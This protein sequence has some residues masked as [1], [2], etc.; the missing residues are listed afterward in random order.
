MIFLKKIK[1]DSRLLCLVC[2]AVLVCSCVLPAPEADAMLSRLNS[3]NECSIA[4][5]APADMPGLQS[6]EFGV[7]VFRIASVD[8]DVHYTLTDAFSSLTTD[9]NSIK[10][11]VTEKLI[12]L[13]VE[14][15]GLVEDASLQ[16]QYTASVKNGSGVVTDEAGGKLP[17]GLY[18][19]YPETVY[20]EDEIFNMDPFIVALPNGETKDGVEDW[21]YDI[22]VT[23]KAK[24]DDRVGKVII[25]KTFLSYNATFKGADAVFK[26]KAVKHRPADEQAGKAAFDDVLFNSVISM[27]FETPGYERYEI[28]DLPVGTEV[29]VSEVYS[30]GAYT[31]VDSSVNYSDH[32]VV[33][34]DEGKDSNPAPLTFSFVNDYN[35]S[36]KT[37]V[38]VTNHYE[39]REGGYSG[40]QRSET[41]AYQPQQKEA[42]NK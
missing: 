13:A 6:A 27:H 40:E 33:A 11:N 41:P 23:L 2:A 16:P 18:L 3:E 29:T 14:A 42:D 20:T 35:D 1:P 12:A 31:L 22:T 5:K 34:Y 26:V 36:L 24:E 10:P 30:G 15:A 8:D 19:I 38:S 21:N 37:S 7:S 28:T 32:F 17:T 39:L 4:L 25:E 9:P